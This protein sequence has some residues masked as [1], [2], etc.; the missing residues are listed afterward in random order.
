MLLCSF[1][2]D[3]YQSHHGTNAYNIVASA[4]HDFTDIHDEIANSI[5]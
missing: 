3:S 1:F 2:R 5:F 4:K